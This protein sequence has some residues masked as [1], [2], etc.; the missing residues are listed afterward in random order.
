M[1]NRSCF[2]RPQPFLLLVIASMTVFSFV[3]NGQQNTKAQGTISIGV[4]SVDITPEGPIRLTGYA[5]R[6]NR[7]ATEAIH[8]LAAK[9]MAFGSDDQERSI[10]ITVDLVGIPGRITAD[11]ADRLSAKTGIDAAHI[12]IC[13]SHTHGGPEVGNLLNI[14][15]YRARVI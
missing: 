5:N 15:Q 1:K 14:L 7:E 2:R 12:A 8:R 10:L 4:A 13:A 6:G 11:L 9:A 3:C